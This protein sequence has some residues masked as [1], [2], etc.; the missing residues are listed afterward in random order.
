MR[1]IGSRRVGLTP[2]V[3][4]ASGVLMVITVIL[5][6]AAAR[7]MNLRKLVEFSRS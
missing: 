6:L 1:P 3:A 5:L 2:L 7:I 4:A